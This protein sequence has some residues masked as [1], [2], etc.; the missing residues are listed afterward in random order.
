MH[1]DLKFADKWKLSTISFEGHVFQR[2]SYYSRIIGTKAKRAYRHCRAHMSSADVARIT[3]EDLE[4]SK[5]SRSD[6]KLS[7]G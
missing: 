3:S 4:A 5:A 2:I 6:G 7:K 1:Q